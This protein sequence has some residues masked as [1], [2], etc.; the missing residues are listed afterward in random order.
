MLDDALRQLRFD[1]RMLER[2]GWTTKADVERAL[3]E[4]PDVE[5]KAAPPDTNPSEPS[6]TPS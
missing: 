5:S 6:N 1:R 3:A 4:L 2:R